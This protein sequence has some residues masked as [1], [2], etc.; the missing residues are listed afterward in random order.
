MARAAL[1]VGVIIMV[2]AI[3]LVLQ[4]VL[5]RIQLDGSRNNH[6]RRSHK[7]GAGAGSAERDGVDFWEDAHLQKNARSRDS[8][9]ESEGQINTALQLENHRLKRQLQQQQQ[10]NWEL[11]K[12][13]DSLAVNNSHHSAQL[14]SSKSDPALLPYRRP[15]VV[16]GHMH[17]SK[18]GGTTLNGNLSV[19]FER[20]CGHRGY[21]YDAHQANER[22]HKQGDEVNAQQNDSIAKVFKGFSRVRVPLKIREEIGFEDCDWI[23]NA[24]TRTV[25]N[26]RSDWRFWGRFNSWD[27]PVELH[28]PCRDPVDHLLSQCNHRGVKFTCSGDVFKQARQC[29]YITGFSKKLVSAFR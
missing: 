24:L 22:S 20:V 2:L 13:V 4:I 14:L 29:M 26:P 19:L 10:L 17:I 15:P 1:N 12:Q 28:V 9:G 5:E 16:F 18:T 25:E 3:M 23:S 7:Q 11:A 6:N 8:S 27:L 21:S